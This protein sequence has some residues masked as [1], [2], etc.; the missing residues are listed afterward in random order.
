[1]GPQIREPGECDGGQ[2]IRERENLCVPVRAAI[3][4]DDYPFFYGP[5]S[6]DV[7]ITEYEQGTLVLDIVERRSK[8]LV[9]RGTARATLLENPTPE[10]STAR[11]NE[12]VRKI[13]AGFPP[14]GR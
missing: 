12:A 7:I 6:R 2:S 5:P 3:K 4:G 9:W 10:R 11:I 1:M 14:A 8:K 13:L